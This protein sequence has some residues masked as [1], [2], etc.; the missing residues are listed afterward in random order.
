[1]S[2]DRRKPGYSLIREAINRTLANEIRENQKR[3]NSSNGNEFNRKLMEQGQKWFDS[4]LKL[5]DAPENLKTNKN[6]IDGFNRAKRL[7]DI[8]EYQYN[9]GLQ[10]AKSGIALEQIPEKDRENPDVIRGYEDGI[11]KKKSV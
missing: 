10:Y 11:K 9:L 2:N 5:E 1:M 3:K 8:A 7:K 6:F 4:G